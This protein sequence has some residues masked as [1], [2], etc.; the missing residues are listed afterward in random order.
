MLDDGCWDLQLMSEEDFSEVMG[1]TQVHFTRCR[2]RHCAPVTGDLN[3]QLPNLY[4]TNRSWTSLGCGQRCHG[5]SRVRPRSGAYSILLQV[6]KSPG[7]RVPM[8]SSENE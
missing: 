7:P 5:K 6:L 2:L 4:N 3:I 8:C 1:R